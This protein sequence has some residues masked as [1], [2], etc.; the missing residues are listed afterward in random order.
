MSSAPR[1]E[2]VQGDNAEAW[3]T[4]NKCITYEVKKP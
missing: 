1:I 4:Y 3:E 2:I